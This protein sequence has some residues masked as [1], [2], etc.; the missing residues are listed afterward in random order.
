MTA[1]KSRPRLTG[2]ISML[3]VA[4]FATV[5]LED[6]NGLL[7][8]WGH[9][10]GPI[11]RPFGSQAWVLNIDGE[12]VSVA[13]S[14]STVSE[15]AGGYHRS[16][17]VELGRLCPRER[18]ANRVMLRLWR[19]VAAPRWPYW[20]PLAAVSYSLNS[21]HDG[22]LY[23]FDGWTKVRDD[24]GSSGGGR[25]VAEAVRHRRRARGQDAVALAVRGGRRDAR[26]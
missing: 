8:D 14:A 13:V 23:R 26:N 5:P 21:R 4:E 1:L 2:Q 10:L 3:P 17:L 18:W 11:G 20:T 25:L 22:Q 15:T 6:A 19:E 9:E 7:A 16:Q 24:C 12:P